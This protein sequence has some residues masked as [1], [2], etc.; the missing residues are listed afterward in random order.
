MQG[1]DRKELAVQQINKKKK[2]QKTK[3][4]NDVAG[5]AESG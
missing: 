5:E 2:K 4:T 1:D 3:Q